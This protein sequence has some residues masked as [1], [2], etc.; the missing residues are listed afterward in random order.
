MAKIETPLREE[1][2]VAP[3][4]THHAAYVE[5]LSQSDGN[6]KDNVPCM[7]SE[8]I[9]CAICLLADFLAYNTTLNM[10]MKTPGFVIGELS[11]EYF[12]AQSK[13]KSVPHKTQKSVNR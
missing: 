2:W 13:R 6:N 4:L 5:Y 9:D 11:M 8:K 7:S 10:V 12:T 3:P 1:L